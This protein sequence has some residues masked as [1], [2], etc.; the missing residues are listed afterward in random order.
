MILFKYILWVL[1]ALYSNSYSIPVNVNLKD[2]SNSNLDFS[3]H[4][5]N[6][7][8]VQIGLSF[9]LLTYSD[10]NNDEG[11][12]TAVNNTNTSIGENTLAI[13]TTTTTTITTTPTPKRQYVSVEEAIEGFR[14]DLIN[15]EI[16]I[17]GFIESKDIFYRHFKLKFDEDQLL[18]IRCTYDSNYA[19][20]S[21][22]I[23]CYEY[24]E[25]ETE[26]VL[27][28]G[29]VE[30]IKLQDPDYKSNIELVDLSKMRQLYH[31]DIS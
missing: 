4:L 2:N 6:N 12:E 16:D 1:F 15:K 28:N 21:L 14:Q 5:P 11:I 7:Q 13:A 26:R 29:E 22:K 27:S 10:V 31:M 24:H 18:T 20:R 19:M 9:R 30:L 25:F 23:S 8:T 17:A 3:L